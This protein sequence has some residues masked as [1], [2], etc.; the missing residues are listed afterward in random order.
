L[1]AFQLPTSNFQLLAIPSLGLSQN[2]DDSGVGTN[3]GQARAADGSAKVGAQRSGAFQGLDG[4]T[5]VAHR[6][7][8]DGKVLAALA[9]ITRKAWGQ[10]PLASRLTSSASEY[11]SRASDSRRRASARIA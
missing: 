11:A 10:A 5:L 9:T 4:A 1:E 6:Q 7:V 2:P 8:R 3:R